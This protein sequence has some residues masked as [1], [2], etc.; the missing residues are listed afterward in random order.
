M[1][2]HWLYHLIPGNYKTKSNNTS[3]KEFDEYEVVALAKRLNITLDDMKEMSFVS[4]ANILLSSVEEDETKEA[5]QEEI[6]R[7]F[8]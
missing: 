6:D 2:L 5:T 7:Y 4:L 8:G 1:L 3:N